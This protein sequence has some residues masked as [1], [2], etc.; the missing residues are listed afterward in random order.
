MNLFIK[1]IPYV[2]ILFVGSCSTAGKNTLIKVFYCNGQANSPHRLAYVKGSKST[3][4]SPNDNVYDPVEVKYKKFIFEKK[5]FRIIGESALGDVIVAFQKKECDIGAD[6]ASP[7]VCTFTI[8][9]LKKFG[10]GEVN[11]IND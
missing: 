3:L 2:L 5:Q 11:Y 7:Y 1:I 9:K 10:C 8:G 4:L 6:N